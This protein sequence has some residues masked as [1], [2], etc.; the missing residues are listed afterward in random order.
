MKKMTCRALVVSLLALSFQTANAGMIGADRAAGS[1]PVDRAMVLNAMDRA[2]T[3]TQLQAQGIDPAMARARVAAMTDE[4][5]QAMAQDIQ[6]APA[7]AEGFALL[8][9][10]V[11]GIALFWHYAYRN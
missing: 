5:V 7:G 6:T 8:V 4:E 10:V 2:E 1:A 3:A 11:I 9:F